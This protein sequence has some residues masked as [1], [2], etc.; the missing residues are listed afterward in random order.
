MPDLETALHMKSFENEYQKFYL[1]LL[2]TSQFLESQL[3]KAFKEFDLTIPQYNVLRILRGQK[4]QSISAVAIQKR[5]IHKTSNISRILDKLE[6]KGLAERIDCN[7][8]RR[9]R[10]VF[11]LPCGLALLKEVEYLIQ[12]LYNHLENQFKKTNT[13][14]QSVNFLLDTLREINLE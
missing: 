5:M 10:N 14:T 2:Y 9:I 6:D 8:N 4:G 13:D 1:N 7:N 11:I 12:N 3:S